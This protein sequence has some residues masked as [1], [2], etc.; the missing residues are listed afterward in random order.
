MQVNEEFVFRRGEKYKENHFNKTL[1]RKTGFNSRLENV[2]KNIRFFK[3]FYSFTQKENYIMNKFKFLETRVLK[4]KNIFAFV[5][6]RIVVL[7]FSI[8]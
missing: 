2:L 6:S 7:K 1:Y 5:F 8:F 4:L 3:Y